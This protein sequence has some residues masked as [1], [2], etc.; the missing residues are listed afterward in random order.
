MGDQVAT[1]DVWPSIDTSRSVVS[2]PSSTPP[3]R[4]RQVTRL[5]P[6]LA[7][8]REEAGP[9]DPTGVDSATAHMPHSRGCGLSMSH[10]VAQ[11]IAE[12]AARD[13]AAATCSSTG[14]D[15]A[16]ARV[17]YS[18][19]RGLSMSHV[20]AQLISGAAARD[21]AAAICSQKCRRRPLVG[22]FAQLAPSL[23]ASD[24][25]SSP[26]L[27]ASTSDFRTPNKARQHQESS[28]V[29][30]HRQERVEVAMQR[31]E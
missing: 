15:S 21:A 31:A 2:V 8:V 25:R 26:P 4:R 11:L 16:T 1:G 27:A 3:C 23:A 24:R 12:A 7:A 6:S 14:V 18:R 19:G 20:A 9:S 10:A 22:N 17:P 28:C 13:A 29:E 30:S 5:L